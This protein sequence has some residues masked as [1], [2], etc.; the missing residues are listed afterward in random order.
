MSATVV[1]GRT[2]LFW[3]ACFLLLLL[4]RLCHVHVLWVDEAYGIAAARRV[5]EG[6]ALYRDVWFDKPPL[7][8]W[9]NL[10]WGA[11]T[12]WPLRL[13]GALFALLCCWLGSRA[14]GTLFTRREGYAAAAALAFFLSFDHAFAVLPLA[15]D[16]L[17]LPFA[18]ATVWA[19]AAGRSAAAGLCAAAGLLAN[20]KALLLLPLALLWDPRR[21]W[22]ALAAWAAGAAAAWLLAAGWEEPVW[23]WG[24]AYSSDALSPDPLREGVIRTVNWSGFHLALIAAAAVY[25]GRRQPHRLR[26]AAWTALSL[27]SVATGARFFPR[28]YFALLAPLSVAAARGWSFV[29]SRWL[30]AALLLSLIIPGVRFGWR[31]IG[32]SRQDSA[33]MR[34]LAMFAECQDAA[35]AI[36]ARSAPGDTLLVWGYR[37]ELNVLAGLRGA[38]RFLDSQPLTGVIADRHLSSSWPTFPELARSHRQELA[39]TAPVFIADGLGPYNPELAI[40]RFDDLREWLAHYELV[41]ETRG[42]RIYRRR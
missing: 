25:F 27:A 28:Y 2:A 7:Y 33:A 40:T 21:C 22:R 19:L 8:A 38:T 34:D 15:P 6:A 9:I 16:L 17:L 24:A 39:R 42:F 1:R 36:R 14:A 4:V 23:K 32:V 18:F 3:S 29:R 26:L 35:A 12:G 13:G 11:E 20:A 10:L 37:P 5:L 31:H 30:A 41:A